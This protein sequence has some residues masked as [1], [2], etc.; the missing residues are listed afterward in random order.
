M[1]TFRRSAEAKLETKASLGEEPL[2]SLVAYFSKS[3]L[4]YSGG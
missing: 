4:C 3:L 1:A 2:I